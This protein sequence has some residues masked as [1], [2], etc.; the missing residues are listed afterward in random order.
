MRIAAA[1]AAVDDVPQSLPERENAARRDYQR[2]KRTG[3]APAIWSKKPAQARQL[4]DVTLGR[5]NK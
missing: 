4:G 3:D 1:K 5:G 2:C